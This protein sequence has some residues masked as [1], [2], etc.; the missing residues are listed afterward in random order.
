MRLKIPA[1]ARDFVRVFSRLKYTIFPVLHCIAFCSFLTF[2]RTSSL[3]YRL[4]LSPDGIRGG[5]TSTIMATG[6]EAGWIMTLLGVIFVLL[7]AISQTSCQSCPDPY[8]DAVGLTP[9]FW[10][11]T[12]GRHC[13]IEP[14]S[15]AA[16]C[17]H[18]RPGPGL[19]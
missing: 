10:T 1:H 6:R 17:L 13:P 16:L 2:L 15:R 4:W 19:L 7:S 9:M 3:R 8:I 11:V 5:D 14:S 18:T 12:M